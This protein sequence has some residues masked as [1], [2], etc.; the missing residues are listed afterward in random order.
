MTTPTAAASRVTDLAG[1]ADA[2]RDEYLRVKRS[3][4]EELDAKRNI[5]LWLIEARKQCGGHGK[6]LPWLDSNFEF[7]RRF[8]Y[9]CLTFAKFAHRANLRDQMGQWKKAYSRVRKKPPE[10]APDR[11]AAQA[12]DRKDERV[13]AGRVGPRAKR[14]RPDCVLSSIAGDNADLIREAA[15]LYLRPG[16]V[17]CDLTFG[18]G[19][20]WSKTDTSGITLLVSDLETVRRGKRFDFRALPYEDNS[21]DVVA[22]DPPYAHHRGRGSKMNDCYRYT[23]TA[24]LGHAGIIDLYRD[25]MSEAWR[26]LRPGGF[27]WVK[28]A[29]EI[30]SGRQRW[31]HIE[32]HALAVSLGLYARDL[33]VLTPTSP[34]PPVHRKRQLHADKNHSFLWVFGK[35]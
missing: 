29:D 19:V 24:G 1:L 10:P 21:A 16:D 28:C 18:R 17:V 20:F 22:L 25:G 5:G 15:R 4:A 31:S 32:I 12:R 13:I 35:P 8:A 2:V 27:L 3:K 7:S 11:T 33:F 14:D 9:A 23:T 34:R 6:W 26:V 30:E